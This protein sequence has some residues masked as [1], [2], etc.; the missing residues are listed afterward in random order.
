MFKLILIIIIF[1][2]SAYPIF[3]QQKESFTFEKCWELYLDSPA[4]HKSASD[5]QK[6]SFTFSDANAINS[7]DGIGKLY[8]KT[9]TANEKIEDLIS[10]DDKIIVHSKIVGDHTNDKNIIKALSSETGIT[11]WRVEETTEKNIDFLKMF[12]INEM[13]VSIYS[14][15]KINK[16]NSKT[17]QYISNNN[18]QITDKIIKVLFTENEIIYYLNDKNKLTKLN[19]E[20][21]KNEVLP[22]DISESIDGFYKFKNYFLITSGIGKIYAFF[23]QNFIKLWTLQIG[24]GITNILENKDEFII[25]SNDNFIYCVSRTS[26]DKK[27]KYKS[28]ARINGLID[29]LTNNLIITN[30]NEP[31]SY[32]IN[33]KGKIISQIILDEN[34]FFTEKP[35]QVSNQII[36]FTKQGIIS[37]SQN[38][39]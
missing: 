1:T 30:L 20:T 21:E 39:C 37:Y 9:E 36:Y 15:G 24:A 34:N 38:K 32:V 22:I 14:N 31:I 26:G 27:W 35:Y 28:L 29:N 5:N 17:G 16:I 6:K 25:L 23:E 2:Y 13:V 33:S 3:T 11:K 19:V 7:V 8:W 4:L 18:L 10:N 12:I